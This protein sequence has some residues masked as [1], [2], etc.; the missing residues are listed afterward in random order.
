MNIIARDKQGKFTGTRI[1]ST[2]RERK[3][4]DMSRKQGQL[5]ERLQN[6]EL[7][8]STTGNRKTLVVYEKSK[9][10]GWVYKKDVSK[11]KRDTEGGF[12]VD[13]GEVRLKSVTLERKFRV[14]RSFKGKKTGV[15][16]VTAEIATYTKQQREVLAMKIGRHQ[17]P[18]LVGG[19]RGFNKFKVNMGRALKFMGFR[20]LKIRPSP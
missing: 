20:V 10:R 16:Q 13:K 11:L 6:R 7:R 15:S 3:L 17:L 12:M 9:Y 19:K 4:L 1:V 5:I 18:V 14:D 8:A 2:Q